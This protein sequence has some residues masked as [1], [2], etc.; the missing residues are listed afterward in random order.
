MTNNPVTSPIALLPS[1]RAAR[2]PVSLPVAPSRRCRSPGGEPLTPARNAVITLDPERAGVPRTRPTAGSVAADASVPCSGCR[3]RSRRRF[4]PAARGWPAR[5]QRMPDLFPEPMPSWF[6]GGW[7]PAPSCSARAMLP[8]GRP[9]CR[10]TTTSS[11]P[12]ATPGPP[13]AARVAPPDHPASWTNRTCP[14]SV[15]WRHAPAIWLPRSA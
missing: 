6:G 3:Q 14:L 12:W 5:P 7:T 1:G 9:A 10:P 8:H 2:V 4:G 13:D 15:R 11:A